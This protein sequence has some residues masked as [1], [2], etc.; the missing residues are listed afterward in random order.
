MIPCSIK[1]I[2]LVLFITAPL[3]L[4]HLFC[5]S[6][7]FV[8][9]PSCHL[10]PSIPSVTQAPLPSWSLYAFLVSMVTTCCIFT[11]V[12]HL[13]YFPSVDIVKKATVNTTEPESVGC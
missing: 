1:Q 13:G 6:Y 10:Y 4:L 3:P 5:L 9:H 2:T 11:F 12:G 7:S 8:L